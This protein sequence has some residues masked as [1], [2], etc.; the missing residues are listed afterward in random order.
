MWKNQEWLNAGGAEIVLEVARRMGWTVEVR[1]AAAWEFLPEIVSVGHR[2]NHV[3]SI[4]GE[5]APWLQAVAVAATVDSHF[6]NE[7]QYGQKEYV[8]PFFHNG[9]PLDEFVVQ[10]INQFIDRVRFS[11]EATIALVGVARFV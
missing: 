9:E 7:L 6:K 5:I 4:N 8:L 10:E 1:D 2:E 11:S 3:I